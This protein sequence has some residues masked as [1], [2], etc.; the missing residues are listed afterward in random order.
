MQGVRLRYVGQNMF[1]GMHLFW[2]K[3]QSQ[4]I[5]KFLALNIVLTFSRVGRSR[6]PAKGVQGQRGCFETNISSFGQVDTQA[7]GTIAPQCKRSF[8]DHTV[9]GLG[10]AGKRLSFGVP[11]HSILLG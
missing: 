1:D 10:E 8:K 3:K 7:K 5:S 2:T 4:K 11:A 6:T 9:R